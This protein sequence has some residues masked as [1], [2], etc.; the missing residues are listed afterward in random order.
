MIK[1]HPDIVL[2]KPAKLNLKQ[3]K[4]FNKTIVS[5]FFKKVKTIYETY[6]EIPLGQIYNMDEKGVQLR[7]EK[8]SSTRKYMYFQ[9]MS[10]LLQD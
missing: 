6:G 4:N 9:K 10:K 8:K 7:G 1:R 5:D 2:A 3:A